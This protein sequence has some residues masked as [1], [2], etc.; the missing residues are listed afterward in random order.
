MWHLYGMGTRLVNVR[1][2][3]E[4]TRKARALRA[5]G[6]AISDL[7]REAI[8]RRYAQ[9]VRSPKGLDVAVIMRRIFEEHPDPPDLAPRGYNVHDRAAARRAILR[10]LRR[11]AQ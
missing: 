7:L 9:V 11:K 10:R 3:E 8:D 5:S 2:D 1:L 4:R 6:I